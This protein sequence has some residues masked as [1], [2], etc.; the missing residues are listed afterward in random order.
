MKGARPPS[1]TPG[2]IANEIIWDYLGLSEDWEF[3]LK[4]GIENIEL[5]N[6]MSNH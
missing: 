6:M 3:T 2:C 4:N 5:E 1:T